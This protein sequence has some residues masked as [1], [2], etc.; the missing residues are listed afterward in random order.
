MY[1]KSKISIWTFLLVC[2]ELPPKD[3]YDN[4]FVDGLQT[5]ENVPICF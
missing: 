4:I 3:R 1:E 5:I 2:N